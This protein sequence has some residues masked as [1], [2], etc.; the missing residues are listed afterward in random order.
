MTVTHPSGLFQKDAFTFIYYSVVHICSH[1]L[2]QSFSIC[3]ISLLAIGTSFIQYILNVGA[4]S[5][6]LTVPDVDLNTA[7]VMRCSSFKSEFADNTL[8]ECESK[9]ENADD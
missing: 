9:V 1:L 5:I 7:N 8:I 3:L 6:F 4:C 2:I